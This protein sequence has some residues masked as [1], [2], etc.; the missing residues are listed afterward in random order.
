MTTSI[1]AVAPAKSAKESKAVKAAKAK[2]AEIR[3]AESEAKAAKAVIRAKLTEIRKAQ[4]EQRKKLTELQGAFGWLRDN[5]NRT[6]SSGVLSSFAKTILKATRNAELYKF[7]QLCAIARNGRYSQ[8][9][10]QAL[11]HRAEIEATEI[12]KAGTVY[13]WLRLAGENLHTRNIRSLK[14]RI[15]SLAASIDDLNK[16]AKSADNVEALDKAKQQHKAAMKALNEANE[17]YKAFAEYVA[18]K[19]ASS[20]ALAA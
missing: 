18:A 3:K 7:A 19:V 12:D 15:A 6:D 11:Y 20:K 8:R 17:R 9:S 10:V 4:S 1:K 2:E 14:S 5:L 16:R 13:D